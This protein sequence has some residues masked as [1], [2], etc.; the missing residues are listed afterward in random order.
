M[1]QAHQRKEAHLARKLE[2]EKQRE[3]ILL[4]RARLLSLKDEFDGRKSGRT[5]ETSSR[6]SASS[7]RLSLSVAIERTK[8]KI[9]EFERKVQTLRQENQARADLLRKPYDG[10]M[11]IGSYEPWAA[12]R[13]LLCSRVRKIMDWRGFG[14]YRTR[15]P[16]R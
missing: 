5:S 3:E 9:P 1:E 6:N 11:G 2:L 7:S 14:F 12:G 10:E 4:E 15:T 13:F 8:N 16:Q